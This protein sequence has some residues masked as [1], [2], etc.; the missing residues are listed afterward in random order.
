MRPGQRRPVLPPAVHTS[1]PEGLAPLRGSRASGTPG[2]GGCWRPCR[3][4]EGDSGVGTRLTSRGG[5]S[6]KPR[7]HVL[8]PRASHLLPRLL[9]PQSSGIAPTASPSLGGPD[10]LGLRGL[11]AAGA[12]V[13]MRLGAEWGPQPHCEAARPSAQRQRTALPGHQQE[14][15]C[16]AG[17]PVRADCQP[18]CRLVAL[19]RRCGG[20]GG[21]VCTLPLTASQPNP[22]W[23]NSRSEQCPRAG[24]ARGGSMAEAE[25]RR[26][27]L[28]R[29]AARGTSPPTR[30]RPPG[31]LAWA[32]LPAWRPDP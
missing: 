1:F 18:S 6:P 5:L 23:L 15:G 27:R 13:G 25:A 29:R 12:A 14:A 31:S 11:G 16:Q 30:P 24:P 10:P 28:P 21:G 17:Q 19:G 8:P 9:S 4:K 3:R 2:R 26:A 32:L 20:A 22:R 7:G